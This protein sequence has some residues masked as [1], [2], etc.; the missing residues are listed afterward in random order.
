MASS[1][2]N[3]ATPGTSAAAQSA[4]RTPPAS[5][6]EFVRFLTTVEDPALVIQKLNSFE[7]D[8][9]RDALLASTLEG[10]DDA[11]DVLDAGKDTLGYLFIL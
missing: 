6:D 3:A 11:L 7:S 1:T 8:K 9:K 4:A 10:G 2:T 5:L